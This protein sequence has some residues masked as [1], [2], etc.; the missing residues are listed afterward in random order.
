LAK[1]GWLQ[2]SPGGADKEEL[3]QDEL[4]HDQR[5]SQA[6]FAMLREA[7][8]ACKFANGD[9]PRTFRERDVQAAKMSIDVKNEN[10]VV[11][12]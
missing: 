6:D 5:V 2:E 8:C 4:Q 3:T 1:N 10:Y 9:E 7:W 11:T 12:H